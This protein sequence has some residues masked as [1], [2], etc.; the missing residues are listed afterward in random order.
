MER[1][2]EFLVLR[3]LAIAFTLF[4]HVDSAENTPNRWIPQ[5]AVQEQMPSSPV[6]LSKWKDHVMLDNGI[7]KLTLLSPSGLIAGIQYKGVENVLDYHLREPRRGYWDI[8]WSRPQEGKSFFYELE[9]TSFKV[10]AETEDMIEISFTRIWNSSLN[11]SYPLNVDIRY[12]MLRGSSGFYSYGIME[13]LEGWPDLNIDEARISFKLHDA[14]F[15]Y[16]AISDDIQRIMPTARDRMGG[17]VLDYKEAVLLTNP[18]NTTLKGEVDD[19]YQYS[20]DN[21]DCF[22]HGWIST[23]R[24]IGFWVITPSNEFRAGGPMKNELTSHVGPTSLAIFFSGHYAGPNFGIRLRNGEPWKKVLGPVFI[25]LNSGSSNKPSTLWADAKEQMQ[26]E[27][28]KWPYDFPSSEDFPR[29]N[30]RGTITGR[31]LVRDTYLSQELMPAKLAYVGLAPPGDVGSWQMDTKGYQFW[32]QTDE[33]GYFTI[34]DVRKGTYSL[35]AWAPGVMGDYKYEIDI[36]ITP[37]SQIQLG[38]LVYNP[39]R[40]GPTLWEI[41]IPDRTP[42]EFYV[43]DPTPEFR[44]PIFINHNEKYRQYGLWN[45]YTDLYPDQD[46]VYTVGISDYKKDWFYAHVNRKSISTNK[47]EATTWQV[48][49]DLTNVTNGGTYT[50]QIALASASYAEIQVRINNPNA[51]LPHFTTRLIGKDNAIAR[52]GGHG[53]YSLYSVNVPGL[54]LVNGRNIIYLKKSRRGYP[55]SGAMYDYIRFEG[56]P[57]VNH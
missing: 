8:V 4:L 32:N 57:E 27:T 28:Q 18:S 2:Q 16:M 5:N 47:Y 15:R 55:F 31:L 42:A 1:V 10:I 56:P 40:N 24:D 36:V 33:N 54:Q 9:G 7:V 17:R 25:Y 22:V 19:K 46:L 13:H 50:L 43:P 45:R 52:H 35:N 48:S 26:K 11:Y 34:R 20:Y 41:G 53:L 29:A 39:P 6:K 23:D 21:K 3:F 37:G 44:N 14:T 49:F 12:I 51:P 30:K 38:N